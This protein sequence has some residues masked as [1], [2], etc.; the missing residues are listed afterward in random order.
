MAVGIIA[1]LRVV[2][3]KQAEFEAGFA[4]MQ[5]V[6]KVEEPRCLLYDLCQDKTDTT[7]YLVMEQYADEDA[8]KNHGTSDA[9]KA[10]VGGLGGCLAGA[11]ELVE[12]NIIS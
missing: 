3:G 7:T 5:E 9:F 1:T 6:V 8:R 4:K 11:P 10:A 12:V 2:E